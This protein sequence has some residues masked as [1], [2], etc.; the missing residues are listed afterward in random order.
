ML[1]FAIV[2]DTHLGHEDSQ[3]PAQNWERAALE[4]KD[5]TATFVLHLGDIVDRA[6]EEQ[7]AVHRDIRNLIGKPVCEIP[8]NHDPEDLFRK[9]IRE[10]I[11]TYF[12]HADVRF[13][14]FSN[15]DPKSHDGFISD[16]QLEWLGK[17]LHEADQEDLPIMICSHVP[18]HEN[19]APDRAWYVKPEHGQTK[20]YQLVDEYRSRIVALLHGHCHSG[21]R[22]WDD[23]TPINEICCPSAFL[24]RDLNLAENNAPGYNLPEFRPGYLLA[25]LTATTLELQYK[26]ISK[27][28]AATRKIQLT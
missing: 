3:T 21:M 14:L 26:P 6:R 24:N 23:R 11:D 7:Y 18:I 12:D 2:T 19:V 5:S 22:G 16:A 9:H 27:E 10:V 28:V 13:V 8:G 15:A 4:L 17:T 1:R 20:F 25:E